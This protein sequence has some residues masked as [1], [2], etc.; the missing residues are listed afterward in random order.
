MSVIIVCFVE[1]FYTIT[2]CL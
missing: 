1:W 2:C